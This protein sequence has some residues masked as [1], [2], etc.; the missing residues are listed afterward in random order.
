MKS[1][2]ILAVV[3][4]GGK[5]ARLYPLTKYRAKPAVPIAGKFRI[6]DIAISNCLNSDIKK[7]FILTQFN[8]HSLHRHIYD[9]YRFGRLSRGFVEILA[10]QQTS[11]NMNWYQGTADAVR[12]NI[13]FITDV[14]ADY[15][16][17]L[18]GDHLYRMDY[19]EFLKTHIEKK[20]DI[21]ISVKP[22][23]REEASSFG[24]LQTDRKGRILRFI[25]KPD[26]DVLAS[27]MSP[28]L[29]DK[30]PFLAS[31]G[32]YM[33]ATEF[34]F[35]V[36]EEDP[37]DDFGKHIIPS[38]IESYKVYAHRF[39]G[40]W[41]DIGTIEAFFEANLELASI[42]PPF[43]FYDED[44]PVYTRPRFLPGSR[45]ED[46]QINRALLGEG[47]YVRKSVISNAIIG[48]RT[49]IGCYANIENCVI[50]GADYYES[51]P[52]EGLIPIGIGN[53]CVVK[54]AII[55][56]NARIGNG[57]QI[58]NKKGVKEIETKRY[59]IRDGI[60]VIPKN[61]VIENGFII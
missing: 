57:V 48:I 42:N 13:S 8:T 38:A 12:Q 51:I 4:G 3:L 56:K 21:T 33:F 1:N 2:G 19:R 30:K 10:A 58:V 32:I 49:I 28:G 53:N 18:S 46:C 39:E 44:A 17:V 9:T 16:L 52:P 35:K 43:T 26:N 20:A 61:V 40:Y 60:I 5:G 47:C 11:E 37:S 27:V 14:D 25:E 50:M 41:K 31:M 45:M 59:S 15:T 6:I 22:V 23:S 34:L 36:L 29:P 55:D 7:I 24:I 54:N